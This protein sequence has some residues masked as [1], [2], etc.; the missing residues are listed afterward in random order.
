MSWNLILIRLLLQAL[1]LFADAFTQQQ[2]A[3]RLPLAARVEAGFV[4]VS[5]AELAQDEL[6]GQAA[7]SVQPG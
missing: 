2:G 7:G 3:Q 5:R 1:Q 6:A 4:F